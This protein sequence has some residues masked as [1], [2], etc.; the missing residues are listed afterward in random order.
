MQ[1]K[2]LFGPK[3]VSMKIEFEPAKML[4]AHKQLI[5]LNDYRTFKQNKVKLNN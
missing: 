2:A 3:T 4:D 5:T 1:F